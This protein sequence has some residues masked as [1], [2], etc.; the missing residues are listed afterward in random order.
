MKIGYFLI[1]LFFLGIIIIS[2]NK[3]PVDESSK[4]VKDK[5]SDQ[6]I[7]HISRPGDFVQIKRDM[8][9]GIFYDFDN[10]TKDY[11]LQPDFYPSYLQKGQHDYGRWGVHGYGAFPGEAS[12]NINNFKKDQYVNFYTFIT[13]GEN[14]ETFQGMSFDVDGQNLSLFEFNFSP[15][16]ILLT[17]TFPDRSEYT[18]NNRTYDWAYKLKITLIAKSDI[19][20]GVYR[21]KLKT[22]APDESVQKLY[23]SDVMK[24]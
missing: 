9:R 15:K 13:A 19:P 4:S 7:P 2:A 5:I 21:F 3:F 22:L 12:Y 11:Y 18:V 24:I 8:Q 10:L 20:H 6:N 1:F 23:Y 17:P 16:S 14:I